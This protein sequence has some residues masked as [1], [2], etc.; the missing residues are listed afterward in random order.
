MTEQR[1][2]DVE[3][4]EEILKW[5]ESAFSRPPQTPESISILHRIA[6]ILSSPNVGWQPIDTAPSGE[7]TMFLVIGITQ[8]NVFTGGRPYTTD[9]YCVWQN[10]KGEFS[11]WPHNWPPTHW[12]P[13]PQPPKDY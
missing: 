2:V 9:T 13:L 3:F 7:T 8:G 4:V 10:S 5:M 12:M 11:R 6:A 1:L